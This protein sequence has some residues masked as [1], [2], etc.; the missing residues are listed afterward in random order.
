VVAVAEDSEYVMAPLGRHASNR[1]KTVKW[2]L[3]VRIGGIPIIEIWLVWVIRA[4]KSRHSIDDAVVR[5]QV[6]PLVQSADDKL[7]DYQRDAGQQAADDHHDQAA[8]L[9]QSNCALGPGFGMWMRTAASRADWFV[10][11][12]VGSTTVFTGGVI[13]HR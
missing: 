12:D 6:L 5:H 9:E 2:R 1:C 3:T 11:T 4:I 8:F 13:C 7:C 10:G